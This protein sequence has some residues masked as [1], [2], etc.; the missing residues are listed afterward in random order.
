MRTCAYLLMALPALALAGVPETIAKMDELFAKRGDP[1]ADKE[2]AAFM[3]QALKEYPNE[4]EVVWR[5]AR[6]VSFQA[7]VAQGQPKQVLGKQTWE[8]GDKARALK[9][10]DA[11]GHYYA[12]IGVGTYSE[13][14]GIINALFQG[15]D[16]KYNERLDKAIELDPGLDR[17]GPI[18]LKGRYYG[19]LP[20]PKQDLGKSQQ[21]LEKV[22]AQHPENLRAYWYLA[23][24]LLA[25]GKKKEAKL[26]I[27][28]V[29][30][31]S[32]DYDPAEA[33]AVRRAAEPLKAK[34][35]KELK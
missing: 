12:A 9:P 11:R 2:N 29:Y 21:L 31:G 18:L 4:F 23:D 10:A 16:G 17:S 34:I 7:D 24:T 30:S 28:K 5:A 22:I 13:G 26:A 25:A 15:I 33:R 20:W 35:E 19:V 8:L 1:A 14:L 27:D 3:E 32:P 6:Y